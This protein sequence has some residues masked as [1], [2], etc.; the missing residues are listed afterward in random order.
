[1]TH[2]PNDYHPDHR[3]TSLLVQDAAYMVTVPAVL[4]FKPHL[5]TNPTIVYFSD[6]FKKPYPFTP[7]VVVPIDEVVEQKVDMLHCHESQ[8]YEWL[9]Y[10]GLYL[11]QVPPDPDARRTWLRSHLE[12]VLRRD[13]GLYRDKLYEQCG[14]SAGATVRYAEAFK[15]CEYGSLLTPESTHR[16]FPFFG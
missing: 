5:R 3:N 8:V 11:Q 12:K 4:P 16:L 7:S 1:M 6:A 2:R 14:P 9:P 10:N 15:A 13:A